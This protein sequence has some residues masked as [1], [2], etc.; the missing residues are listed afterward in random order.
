MK[1]CDV[2]EE[3]KDFL[4]VLH[5]GQLDQLLESEV[6]GLKV[7]QK[8]TSVY[9]FFMLDDSVNHHNAKEKRRYHGILIKR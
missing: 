2:I 6:C 4:P 1:F 7:F 5:I 3:L 8:D 9:L